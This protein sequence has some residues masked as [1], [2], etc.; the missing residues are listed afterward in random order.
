MKLKL[1]VAACAIL[2]FLSTSA[3]AVPVP[4]VTPELL[5]PGGTVS[6]LP[7]GPSSGDGISSTKPFDHKQTFSFSGTSG[8]LRERVLDYSDRPSTNHPGLYFDF[9]I[10]LE[11]G[12]I[13]A[14]SITNYGSFTTYVKECGISICGGSGANGVVATSVT[15]TLDGDEITWNFGNLLTGGHHSA[16]LQI[17]SNAPFYKD[18]PAFLIDGSGN[19]LTVE[20]AAPAAAV[21]GPVVGAGVPGLMMAFGG[22]LAWRRRRAALAA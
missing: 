19:S 12:A 18:P 7:N 3:H 15:R 10:T 1:V 17:F 11:T 2:H 4:V 9:E 22:I 14:L 5:A 6:P 21:P 8:T 20:V 16:N 13:S